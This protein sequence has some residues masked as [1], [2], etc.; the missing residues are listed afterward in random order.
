MALAV[1]LERD[2]LVAGVFAGN[3]A[4]AAL[5]T[6]VLVDDSLAHV[7]Q[8]Q[9]APVG[10]RGHGFA[11]DLAHTL[12]AHFVHVIRQTAFHFLHDLEA[13]HHGSRAHLHRTG[14]QGNKVQRIPPG[15][16]A[17]NT[18]DGQARS[19]GVAG[20][21]G[22]HVQRNRLHGRAAVAAVAALAT[23]AG[24][25][26]QG[27]GVHTHDGVDGVDQAHCICAPALGRTRRVADVGDVGSQLHD[28]GQLAVLLA[29]L[30]H[31][32]D[33]LGHLAH[34]CA[35]A[36]FAHAVGA[37]EV[38]F[39]GIGAGVFHAGQ[40]GFPA[41]FL[42]GH[43]E[44]DDHGSFLP[45]ALHFGDL[46]QIQLQVAI[47][48]Q[49]DVVEAVQPAVRRQQGA[50]AWAVH[51]DDGWAGFAQCLP[52]DAAPTCLEG[53]VD[54]VGLVGRRC[55]GEPEGVGAFDAGKGGF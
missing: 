36:A 50:V 19:F 37:A 25:H 35:H 10:H 24:R 7:V 41:C 28:D 9:V 1:F 55:R 32:L 43:H 31:H 12:E 38:E 40:Y 51:V 27:V 42:A 15:A 53:A 20:D 18:A 4:A 13:V 45:V 8:V 54:V 46:A 14:A 39:D 52:D 2:G 33:V 30:G 34:C 23:G 21:L 48:D 11:H 3:V 44:R 16:D 47:G 5:N 6:A 22:H 29:P 17:A 49:L 26:G